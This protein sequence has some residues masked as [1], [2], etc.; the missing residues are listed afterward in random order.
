MKLNILDE[1]LGGVGEG[2]TLIFD[3]VPKETVE[4]LDLLHDLEGT[5]IAFLFTPK[6]ILLN[7]RGGKLLDSCGFWEVTEEAF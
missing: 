1:G 7:V 6:F 3:K 2:Q 5:G 4:A